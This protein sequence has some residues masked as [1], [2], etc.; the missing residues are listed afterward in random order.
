MT[1]KGTNTL[2]PT[3]LRLVLLASIVLLIGLSGVGFWLFSESLNTYAAEVRS[4]NNAASVSSSDIERLKQLKTELE[5]NQ[6]SVTRAKNIVADSKYYQYQD[7]IIADLT[8][9]AKTTKV[10]VTSITF[11][12]GTTS[13]LG[14]TGSTTPGSVSTP[15]PAGLK[16]I[17]ATVSL[18]TPVN[19]Q[20]FMRFVHAIELNLTKM[21]ITGI[22]V[23]RS[24]T[25]GDV[26]VSPLMIEV[27]V[28]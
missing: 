26:V 19:Y 28:R 18:K 1:K 27:Y 16:S 4:A 3:K 8:A 15:A 22:S 23:Q 24:E 13:A 21:Q 17:N 12:T 20:A 14:S 9:Y 2:T 10:Q 6:V 5:E 11:N 25:E 7:Q